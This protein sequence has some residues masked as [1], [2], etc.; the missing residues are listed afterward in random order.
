MIER[1]TVDTELGQVVL[2]SDEEL[3]D[4]QWAP[5]ELPQ[6]RRAPLDVLCHM[7]GVRSA[8][9]LGDAGP[10]IASA[11]NEENADNP[12]ARRYEARFGRDAFYTA[13]FLAHVLL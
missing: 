2:A 11:A 10:V 13:E 12:E 7:A 8:D 3:V 6:R 4:I 1:Y 9:E 5:L